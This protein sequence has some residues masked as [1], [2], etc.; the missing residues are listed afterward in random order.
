MFYVKIIYLYRIQPEEWMTAMR[1]IGY[2]SEQTVRRLFYFSAGVVFLFFCIGWWLFLPSPLFDTPYSTVLLD[3]ENRTI[4]LKVAQDEQYRFPEGN[5]LPAK[6]IQ[7]LLT[8]E[9]KRFFY[10][11][12]VD[13]LALGRAV[14]LNVVSGR[15]VSG[16]STLSMQ[17]VRLCRKNPPRTYW[18]KLKE[19]VCALRLEQSYPKYRI[20]QLYAAHAPFGGN[21]VGLEA[22]SLKYF[23]RSPD[24]LSWAEAA[25]LAVLPNAPSLRNPAVLKRKRNRLLEQLWKQKCLNREDYELAVEEPLPGEVYTPENIAPHLL[26]VAGKERKGKICRSTLDSRLQKRVN[27][28]VERHSRMLGANYIYNM[29]VLVA[30]VPDGEVRAY[31]GNSPAQQG[32]RGNQ[33]DIITSARSSGSILKP[34]LY[35]LMQQHGYLLPHT[36]V[37]DIPSRFGGYAPA[38]FNRSFQGVAPADEALSRSL[39]IPFVH[40]L[41]DYSYTRFYGDLKRLGITTLNRRAEDYGLSLILGG[42]EVSLWD[43]CNMYGGMVSVLRHYNETDGTYFQKEY[44][45]LKVWREEGT[46]VPERST[47]SEAPLQASAVWLTLDA[48]KEVERPDLESGWKNFASRMDLSWKTGTSFGFR[49]AW[50]VGVNADWVVGVWVGNAD[51][52]GR[53]GLVGVRA[54]APVLFEVAALLPVSTRLYEP[55]D[56][57]R[58]VVV[59]RKSGYRASG[60]CTEKDT[61]KVCKM[62]DKVPLCPYHRWIHLDKSGTWQV[63]SGCENISDIRV[64]SWFV[65]TP[66]QEWYYVRTH[67]DY[68]KLP[69]WRSGCRPVLEDMME[70]IYPQPGTRVFIPRDF[71]GKKGTVVFELAHRHPSAEV[72]WHVDNR[73]IGSTRHFHQMRFDTEEG[74]H[75]LTLVDNEG[76]T[77]SQNFRV[78]K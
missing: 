46:E 32:S 48:L 55:V 11:P 16:G 6:Y 1:R 66:V 10:H 53:P 29:A 20:L 14:Y 34:A 78:V 18:E 25:L 28:I 9:D 3:R 41:K 26:A 5:L 70:M 15:V 22:A 4:G 42:A 39:N 47:Y 54:A 36:L 77:L 64:S 58:E 68:R 23:G 43:L 21:I 24:Q 62:G 60:I 17:V 30:H 50:A 67:G 69:A 27:E 76:N 8:F 37:S 13:G 63:N 44:K 74:L 52:E 12:G 51:G 71:G 75:R 33:V 40:M 2:F 31:V 65:L 7:A 73:Y 38:N 35:A 45:R 49:D 19:I 72:Y 59:C 61:I 57:L 56:E